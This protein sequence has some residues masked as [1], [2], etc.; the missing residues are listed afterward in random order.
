L[1]SNPSAYFTSLL[2]PLSLPCVLLK[3]GRKLLA[4]NLGGI[5]LRLLLLTRLPET[6]RLPVAAALY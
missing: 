5:A 4:G 2:K 3:A 1:K 6:A